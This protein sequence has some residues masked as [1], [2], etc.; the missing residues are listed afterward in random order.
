MRAA[1]SIS[2][3]PAARIA[4]SRT[5]R[6]LCTTKTNTTITT[7]KK[8][9][10]GQGRD[11]H[12]S[13]SYD[14]DFSSPPP[15]TSWSFSSSSTPWPS[16]PSPS[17]PSSSPLPKLTPTPTPIHSTFPLSPGE[18]SQTLSLPYS[19]TI[20]RH[21]RVR[22]RRE[23]EKE[24]ISRFERKLK[25][26]YVETKE[27]RLDFGSEGKVEAGSSSTVPSQLEPTS[28]PSLS[29]KIRSRLYEKLSYSESHIQTQNQYRDSSHSQSKNRT[30]VRFRNIK[31][32][33][34]FPAQ[35]KPI[36]IRLRVPQ[37]YHKIPFNHYR[38]IWKYFE[39]LLISWEKEVRV[40]DLKAEKKL[41]RDERVKLGTERLKSGMETWRK[42][43]DPEGDLEEVGQRLR[44]FPKAISPPTSLSPPSPF[45]SPFWLQTRIQKLLLRLVSE[46]QKMD[47]RKKTKWYSSRPKRDNLVS[48]MIREYN[49]IERVIDEHRSMGISKRW[50]FEVREWILGMAPMGEM[51]NESF[52]QD[53][54]T[55]LDSYKGTSV[56]TPLFEQKLYN[57]YKARLIEVIV[58]KWNR[59]KRQKLLDQRQLVL[60]RRSKRGMELLGFIRRGSG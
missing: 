49:A 31:Q 36:R 8:T 41:Q 52:R 27:Y 11:I 7:T 6:L 47:K 28:A 57:F 18:S 54:D 51:T 16:F 24:Q 20:L 40:C 13:T 53:T 5:G 44:L 58:K 45:S 35:P 19:Y 34:L 38:R 43:K 10:S 46:T 39:R 60:Y 17:P 22:E 23:T 1:L 9:R 32:S 37:P 26:M 55:D 21:Q 50:W 15:L 3:R 29:Q 2:M 25:E 42:E 56:G 30:R 48:F 4:A 14:S 59:S 12:S 33:R